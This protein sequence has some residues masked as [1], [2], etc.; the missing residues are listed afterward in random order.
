M[1]LDPTTD[2]A[3]S[4]FLPGHRQ[5]DDSAL[6]PRFF[7]D[8]KLLGLKSHEAGRPIYEDREYIEIKIKGQPKQVVVEEV[9]ARHRQQFPIA[10]AA[11]KQN[12]EMPVVGTPIEQ[13]PGLGPSLAATIKSFGVRTIEDMAALNEIGLQNIGNGARDLQKRAKA[14]L[15]Q[16]SETTVKLEEE[17]KLLRE[18]LAQMNETMQAMRDQVAALV[19]P[20]RR[21]RVTQPAQETAQ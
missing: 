4:S 16:T 10:Y 12:K 9:T 5:E 20:K 19:A 6:I 21:R 8:K 18:Q 1:Q 3:F 17:N 2:S 11:F 13:L 15:A 7:I 14:F